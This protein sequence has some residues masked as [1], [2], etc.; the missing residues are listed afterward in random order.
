MQVLTVFGWLF[1][2]RI[3]CFLQF[4]FLRWPSRFSLFLLFLVFVSLRLLKLVLLL[5]LSSRLLL[6]FNQ[7]CILLHRMLFQIL[8]VLLYVDWLLVQ[9][10]E[11]FYELV[12]SLRKLGI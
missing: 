9:L 4:L 10:V 3:C 1:V 12:V 11:D 8:K 7:L 2:V 5:L 6:F